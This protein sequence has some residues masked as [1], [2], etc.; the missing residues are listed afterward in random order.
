[1]RLVTF[2]ERRVQAWAWLYR[3]RPLIGGALLIP[4]AWASPQSLSAGHG[5]LHLDLLLHPAIG[6]LLTVLALKIAASVI[7]LSFGFRGGL[8]FA[9]LFLGSLVGQI[10]AE[11]LDLSPLAVTLSG[12]DAALVGMAALSVAVVGGPMTLAF[13]ILETTHDFALMG[14]VLT[15]ALISSAF[16]REVFGYSFSTW[17]LHLRGASIRSPR[18]IGWARD[19]TAAR[20]MR[21]DWVAVRDDLS[22]GEFR[23][24]MPLGA[25]SRAVLTDGEA[26]YRGIVPTASAYAPDLDTSLPVA[27]IATLTDAT[28]S[29]ATGIEAMLER[30][31]LAAADELAVVDDEQRVLGIVTEKHARRRYFDE[32]EAAQRAMFGES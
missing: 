7:S 3:W 15:A 10:F 5:A 25:A 31:D 27:T 30:F 29:P 6:F 20:V 8:F 9:A 32:I 1:M 13:L 12:N 14:V 26:R 2:A 24:G 18:D 11:A 19:L 17:R 28:L 4:I 16:T 21:R 22:I 23:A